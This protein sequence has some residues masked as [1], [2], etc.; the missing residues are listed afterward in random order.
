[1]AEKFTIKS[2]KE[3]L[4]ERQLLLQQTAQVFVD[5]EVLRRCANYVPFDSGVLNRSGVLNTDLGSGEV[6]YATPYA[7]KWYY[8]PAKFQGAPRRGN[9]WFARMR[10]NGGREAILRGVAK[11]TGGRAKT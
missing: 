2:T 11:I 1:M 3:L 4:S 5:S 7:R 6:V 10:D 8:V 9:Y